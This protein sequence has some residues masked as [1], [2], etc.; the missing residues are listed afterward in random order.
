MYYDEAELGYRYPNFIGFYSFDEDGA[1][2]GYVSECPLSGATMGFE[3]YSRFFNSGVAWHWAHARIGTRRD[4]PGGRDWGEAISRSGRLCP[5]YVTQT[6]PYLYYGL[7]DSVR[8]WTGSDHAWLTGFTMDIDP[9]INWCSTTP[10]ADT[11]FY[12]S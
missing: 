1:I 11:E 7:P 6:P 9:D 4:L 8:G 2:N 10:D 12:E 3:F 5:E